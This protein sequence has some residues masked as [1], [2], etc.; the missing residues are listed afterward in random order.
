M[1]TATAC[2]AILPATLDLFGDAEATADGSPSQP[3]AIAGTEDVPVEATVGAQ[4][5]KIWLSYCQAFDAYMAELARLAA[6]ERS[7]APCESYM[8][9][10]EV[11]PLW[12]RKDAK[13]KFADGIRQRLVRI[14]EQRFAP[15]GVQ[16]SI[17]AEAVRERFPIEFDNDRHGDL[18]QRHRI[19]FD[20]AAC[21]QYLEDTYGGNAGVELAWSQAARALVSAFHLDRQE[22]IKRVS[23]RV[24]IEK[25]VW[26]EKY[27]RGPELC[28]S[29]ATSL[30][31][32]LLSIQQFAEWAGFA[33]L[34]AGAYRA[35]GSWGRG[36]SRVTSREVVPLGDGC[37]FVTYLT[38]FHFR[39][40]GPVAERMQ[41]FVSTYA[42]VVQ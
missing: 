13:K 24:V 37:D 34:S 17:D 30:R 14:A 2:L 21:W 29:S 3:A 20:P 27:G 36:S 35:A 32:A 18:D 38:S 4:Y 6:V 15:E 1:A 22:E 19:E 39:F 16:L 23:G 33:D 25:R 28:C 8:A 40:A 41:I 31:E 12:K 10:V 5:S 7:F 11:P 26:T 9:A 42:P